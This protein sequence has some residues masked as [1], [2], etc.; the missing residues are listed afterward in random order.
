VGAR[1]QPLGDG[2]LRPGRARRTSVWSVLSRL[3]LAVAISVTLGFLLLPLL[4]LFLSMSPVDLIS[5]L[6][7]SVAYQALPLSLETTFVSLIVIIAFG[8]PVAY[9]LARQSFR[10]KRVVEVIL[11][12]P[13]V[14]PPAVTGVGLLLIFGRTGLL[15]HALSVLGVKVAFSAIAV[16]FAQIF[17]AGP[18]YIINSQQAFANVDER[19]LEVSRTLGQSSWA[20]FRRTVVPLAFPGIVAGAAMSLARALGEFGATIVFA[21]NLP[22]RTQT[23]P[24][25]IYTS[26]QYDPEAAV[27]MSALLISIAFSLL[28]VVSLMDR[29]ANLGIR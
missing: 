27:A 14:S 16:V 29:R 18:F 6:H 9:W 24:L 19:L 13:I 11:K 25:A 12:L 15:G 3:V 20:T 2:L 10:G 28:L 5:R 22:G 4:A 23:L 21:G 7:A 17:V 8:T 26:L 1:F